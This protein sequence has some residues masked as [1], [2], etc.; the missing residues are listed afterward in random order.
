MS[1]YTLERRQW[2]PRD[3]DEVFAFFAAPENLQLLTPP[4]LNFEILTPSP[5]PMKEGTFIDYRIR[6]FGVPLRWRTRIAEYTP[7]SDFV[8][9]QMSGPYRVWHHRHAFRRLNGGTEMTDTVTYAL[10]FGIVGD[11]VHAVWTRRT[12]ARIFD[13]RA[14]AVA[15]RFAKT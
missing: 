9:V 15:K 3:L 8:D 12:V 7:P 14:Q 6:L 11:I 4:F 1:T 13:F 5:I 10:P 2:L